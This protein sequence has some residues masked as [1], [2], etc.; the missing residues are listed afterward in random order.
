MY[1]IASNVFRLK[2]FIF[3]TFIAGLT[4]INFVSKS[5]ENLI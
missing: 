4:L 2:L 1:L 3:M 5:V